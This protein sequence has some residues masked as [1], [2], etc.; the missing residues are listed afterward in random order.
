M[1]KYLLSLFVI[2]HGITDII[3][4]YENDRLLLMTCIY[5]FAPLTLIYM[6][7][8]LYRF[9]FFQNSNISGS[10][11]GRFAFIEKAVL[12]R[13]IFSLLMSIY[14]TFFAFTKS[15]LIC[16]LK[17]LIPLNFFS[18]LINFKNSTVNFLL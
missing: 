8:S 7:N 5:T 3:F 15:K 10:L 1:Y 2:P 9:I 6:N 14:L 17:S 12:G 13:L 18:F 11:M 4:S 16:F